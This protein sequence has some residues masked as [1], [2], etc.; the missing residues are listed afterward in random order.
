METMVPHEYSNE[1]LPSTLLDL[2]LLYCVKNSQTFCEYD[3]TSGQYNLKGGI[4]LPPEICESIVQTYMAEGN[5][6]NDNF[7][8]IF[9][10]HMRTHLRRINVQDSYV[11]ETALQWL[12]PHKPTE[13]NISGCRKI[14]S[15]T[16][17]SINQHGRNLTKLFIGNSVT[18]F[19]DVEIKEGASGS[20][21][22]H[23]S[24]QGD[25]DNRVF[26]GDYIFNCPELRA[27][28]VHNLNKDAS[29]AHD[30]IAVTLL[31][32]DKLTYLDL[33]MCKIDIEFMDCLEDLHGL[34][35]LILYGVPINNMYEAFQRIGKL[36]KLR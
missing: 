21:V 3:S 35:S 7:M 12:L 1:D 32:F 29:P 24:A 9:K 8:H 23:P 16:L 31:P 15:R 25:A 36:I 14:T 20:K 2:C 34:N 22:H 27:F 33:S 11:T 18:I 4:S 28:S 5:I 13:L 19:Q 10:D 6:L 26:G 30:I 17:Q